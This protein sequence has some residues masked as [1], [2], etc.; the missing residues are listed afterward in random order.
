MSVHSLV[1]KTA[2]DKLTLNTSNKISKVF[3]LKQVIQIQIYV[4]CIEFVM[5][6]D[7]VLELQHVHKHRKLTSGDSSWQWP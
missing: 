1:K 4:Q 5:H 6:R 3:I 2:A 7:S